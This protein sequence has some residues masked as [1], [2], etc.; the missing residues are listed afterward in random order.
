MLMIPCSATIH[1]HCICYCKAQ[2]Y[3]KTRKY[4]EP[5]I[6]QIETID[7]VLR[8]LGILFFFFLITLQSF[9]LVTFV[10]MIREP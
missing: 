10:Q 8:F 1:N 3:A 2:K 9:L 6:I 4:L 7:G 5:G